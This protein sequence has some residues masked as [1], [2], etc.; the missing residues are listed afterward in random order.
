MSRG[1]IETLIKGFVTNDENV[2]ISLSFIAI[3]IV[4]SNELRVSRGHLLPPVPSAFG[5]PVCKQLHKVS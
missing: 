4:I 1:K 3:F 5:T 2:N